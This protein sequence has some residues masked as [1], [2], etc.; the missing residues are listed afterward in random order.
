MKLTEWVGSRRCS[1]SLRVTAR[2][3]RRPWVADRHG[4]PAAAAPCDRTRD[5]GQRP[6]ADSDRTD[7]EQPGP[8]SRPVTRRPGARAGARACRMM[9]R[10]VPASLSLDGPGHRDRDSQA[11]ATRVPGHRA[12]HRDGPTVINLIMLLN[13]QI[14][15]LIFRDLS[16]P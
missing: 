15:V 13:D 14:T 8:P 12:Q 3:L 5:P 1:V 9:S 16:I 2:S 10:R 7:P 6:A 4:G 11:E